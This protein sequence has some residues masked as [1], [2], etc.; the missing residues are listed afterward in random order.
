VVTA[1]INPPRSADPHVVRRHA[2]VLKG[3][4]DAANVTDSN[5]A[6]VA[7]SSFAA[8]LLVRDAGVEPIVQMTGRDRNRI[9]IQSDLLGI[10]AHGLPNVLCMRGDDPKAGDHPDAVNV[11]DLDGQGILRAALGMREGKKFLSGAE[12]HCPPDYFVGATA[13]PFAQ[14]MEE[15]VARTVEKANV[16]ADFV[17]TQ[18]VF[19]EAVF[20]RWLAAVRAGGAARLAVIAGVMVLRSGQQAERMSTIPGIAV[21]ARIV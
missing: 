21:P 6:Q 4:V 12:I 3:F 16:G 1:E 17:Q 15:E 11:R 5:R 7:M 14:P 19:D 10:A 18:P 13:S 2:G 8:A 9:A 20:A